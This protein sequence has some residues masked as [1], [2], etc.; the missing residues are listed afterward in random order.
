M[1][2]LTCRTLAARLDV[3]EWN[4]HEQCIEG[5]SWVPSSRHLPAPQQKP[6]HQLL[7]LRWSLARLSQVLASEKQFCCQL[8]SKVSNLGRN[9]RWNWWLTLVTWYCW[10][11]HWGGHA[12]GCGETNRKLLECGHLEDQKGNWDNIQIDVME[13]GCED[14]GWIKLAQDNVRWRA[15]VSAVL[16]RRVLLPD[17]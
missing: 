1:F 7:S 17:N 8:L 6:A 5:I 13:I 2:L 15:L 16:N 9:T 10:R 4:R 3:H 12:V 14:G 11:L